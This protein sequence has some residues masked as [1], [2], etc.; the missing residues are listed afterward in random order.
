MQ[1][2]RLA[3]HSVTFREIRLLPFLLRVQKLPAIRSARTP[4]LAALDLP[5]GS[6]RPATTEGPALRGGPA[7]SSATRK[8]AVAALR[9]I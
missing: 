7:I 1:P 9:A 5:A 8:I 2:L 6:G 4:H 3:R